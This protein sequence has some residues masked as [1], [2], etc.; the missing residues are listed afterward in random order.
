MKFSTTN[1]IP[2]LSDE[3]LNG[4]PYLKYHS[5]PRTGILREIREKKQEL[6][7]I[8]KEKKRKKQRKKSRWP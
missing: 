7:T 5:K 2:C 8:L 1:N 6:S 4:K 3:F